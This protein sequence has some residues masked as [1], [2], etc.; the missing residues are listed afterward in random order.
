MT[1]PAPSS[2][3]VDP[4]PESRESRES[5]WPE[6]PR[7]EASTGASAGAAGATQDGGPDAPSGGRRR[8]SG[9]P[10]EGLAVAAFVVS[11]VGV[12]LAGIVL[13]H[14]ALARIAETG[15]G[16]RRLALAALAIGYAGLALVL[17]GWVLYFWLLAPIVTL[18]G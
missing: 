18:P 6:S 16:G 14:L 8:R 3:P 2:A 7:A 5:P 1:D 12:H 9:L 13:G 10:R 15:R 4:Q 11:L 17:V